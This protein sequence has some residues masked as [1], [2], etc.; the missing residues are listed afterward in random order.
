MNLTGTL[1]RTHADVAMRLSCVLTMCAANVVIF[2]EPVRI[3]I[4][5][6]SGPAVGGAVGLR[7][8][9]FKLIGALPRRPSA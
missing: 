7:T 8:P 2:D 6:H 5:L 1:A 3:R 4:G 9:K